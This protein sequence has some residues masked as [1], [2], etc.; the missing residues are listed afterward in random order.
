MLLFPQLA[1]AYVIPHPREREG[2]RNPR[3][4]IVRNL[5]DEPIRSSRGTL[6]QRYLPDAPD[7]RFKKPSRRNISQLQK[8]R[9]TRTRAQQQSK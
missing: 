3:M 2:R 9:M 5:K 6:L 1:L 8:A 7:D 4:E